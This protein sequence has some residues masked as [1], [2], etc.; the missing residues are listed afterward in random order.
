ME[1]PCH[2]LR[3][4]VREFDRIRGR[5]TIE[6]ENGQHAFV[7]YSAIIGQG[8]HVLRS[9]DRVSFDVEQNQR[10]LNAVRVMLD[11]G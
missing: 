4:T 10:G 2:R 8:L 7:R 5:G 6:T 11:Q 1:T 3:G 9:G